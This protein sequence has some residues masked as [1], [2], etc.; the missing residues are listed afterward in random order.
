[1]FVLAKYAAGESSLTAYDSDF[2]VLWARLTVTSVFNGASLCSDEDENVY[3]L[4]WSELKIKVLDSSG[5]LIK[6][7]TI[8]SFPTSIASDNDYIY[9]VVD[10]D[11]NT[12]VNIYRIPIE[13]ANGT[14]INSSYLWFFKQFADDVDASTSFLF[15]RI[16]CGNKSL[17]IVWDSRDS[18]TNIKSLYFI[19]ID[20]ETGEEIASFSEAVDSVFDTWAGLCADKIGNIYFAYQV[21]G[22]NDPPINNFQNIFIYKVDEFG[23]VSLF[24]EF[25]YTVLFDSV[26]YNILSVTPNGILGVGLSVYKQETIVVP[27]HYSNIVV[28]DPSKPLE[29]RFDPFY[30]F[31]YYGNAKII[32]T[33]NAPHPKA[34]ESVFIPESTDSVGGNWSTFEIYNQNGKV[35]FSENFG[36]IEDRFEG[37]FEGTFYANGRGNAFEGNRILKFDPDGSVAV[38]AIPS[39]TSVTGFLNTTLITPA[40]LSILGDYNGWP[41][42]RPETYDPFLDW[43]WVDGQWDIYPDVVVK[44]GGRYRNTMVVVGKDSN[45]KGIIY[46]SA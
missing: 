33:F 37:I 26:V 9:L 29:V 1:M 35:L 4:S 21:R 8:P 7:W 6:T 27:A 43:S 40:Q 15:N 32:W 46:V 3:F 17:S 16:A 25:N 42:P 44:G 13:T 20:L 5:D 19:N 22:A 38:L 12:N 14:V 24:K 45:D 34:F 28:L 36:Q 30:Q 2:N 10:D 39:G 31:T 23:D 11:L 41:I 18:V